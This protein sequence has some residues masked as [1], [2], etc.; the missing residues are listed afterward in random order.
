MMFRGLTFPVYAAEG[1]P[2]LI[3]GSGSHGDRVTSVTIGHYDTPDADPYA[4]DRPRYEITTAREDSPASDELR[5]ARWALHGWL[6]NNDEDARSS[7]PAASHAAVTLWLAARDRTVRG[8]VLAAVCS[9]Q[10]ISIDGTL[11]PFLTLTAGASRWVAVRRHDDLVITIAAS[12]LELTTITLEPIPDP[13]A[14][15]LGPRPS[16][17]DIWPEWPEPEA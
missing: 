14:V 11:A 1:W 6:Q 2:A 17:A 10:L 15:L 13:A 5:H 8:K 7:W 16:G 12:D 3:G 9:E 4:G